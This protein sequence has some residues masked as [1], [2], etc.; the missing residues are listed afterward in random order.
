ME[1][2][3]NISEEKRERIRNTLEKI[4]NLP[5]LPDIVTEAL[6]LLNSKNTSSQQLINII[7]KEQSFVTKVLALANSPIYGLRKEVSSLDFAI[8]VLGYNEL[9][10]IVFVI[11]FLESFR[12][13][14]SKNFDQNAF[15][16]HSFITAKISKRIAEEHGYGKSGEAF[17][18]GFLHDIGVS[19][20]HRYFKNNFIEILDK[21]ADEKNNYCDVE[22]EVVGMSHGELGENLLS[23]WNI[24]QP[25]IN[26][27][28]YHH[29]PSPD[30]N[31]PMLPAIIHLADH[32]ARTIRPDKLFWESGF[33]LEEKAFEILNIEE[34]KREE[35]LNNYSSAIGDEQ[36]IIG[37]LN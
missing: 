23:R 28:V 24:P 32:I 10:H 12:G 35:F 7:S 3:Q 36:D 15:W 18:A 19:I 21:L 22:K 1:Q 30:N 6:R 11:S 14:H 27:V 34:S 25:L 33:D 37:L 8:M 29:S 5:A 13:A 9:R 20:I 31:D 4:Y 17:V 16:L 26:G 2:T